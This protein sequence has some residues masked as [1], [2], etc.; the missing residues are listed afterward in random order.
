MFEEEGEQRPERPVWHWQRS[1][2]ETPVSHELETCQDNRLSQDLGLPSDWSASGWRDGEVLFEVSR[3]SITTRPIYQDRPI[4]QK[5][6]DSKSHTPIF[7]SL[8]TILTHLIWLSSVLKSTDRLGWL[9]NIN[10]VVTWQ[11]CDMSRFWNISNNNMSN[12][13]GVVLL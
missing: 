12:I 2:G 5:P 10:E 8:Q 1:W 6:S 9:S 7:T 3:S 13:D 4:H 11:Y